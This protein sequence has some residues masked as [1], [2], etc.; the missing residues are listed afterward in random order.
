MT[1]F[2]QNGSVIG[3]QTSTPAYAAP[4]KPKL[5]RIGLA[6]LLCA[7]AAC[8]TVALIGITT[9]FTYGLL[10]GLLGIDSR[11]MNSGSDPFRGA[12]FA[13]LMSAMNWYVG[14][15]TIP[16]TW[17]V[18]GF[19]LGRLPHRGIMKRIAY[20]RWGA[21]WGA[22]LVGATT[23]IATYIIADGI[24]LQAFSA[25]LTGAL[26]GALAGLICGWLFLAIV[27]PAE[28]VRRIQVEVF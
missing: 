6:S 19:S 20:Y 3:A 12:S 15:I 22:I 16:V 28:Q 24:L 9:A 5:K 13:V 10:A 7:I 1:E 11:F 25:F 26:I 18:L 8:V 27:R 4:L 23:G 2:G 21:I 17:L 14:Y